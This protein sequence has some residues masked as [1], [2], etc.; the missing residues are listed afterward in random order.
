M[1][2]ELENI[3]TQDHGIDDLMRQSINGH[4]IEPSPSVWKGISRK[5][6]WN[7]ILH[8]NFTNV[9]PRL[10]ISAAIGV[11][12]ITAALYL[13]IHSSP[14][15]T[16]QPAGVKTVTSIPVSTPG[17]QAEDKPLPATGPESAN[18]GERAV[19]AA[20]LNPTGSGSANPGVPATVAGSMTTLNTHSGSESNRNEQFGT[21]VDVTAT[22]TPAGLPVPDASAGLPVPIETVDHA[23]GQK[24]LMLLTPKEADL[25]AFN[26]APDT[27]IPVQTIHGTVLVRK[28]D[29]SH[30]LFYAASLGIQPEAAFNAG[31]KTS[32]DFSYW[33]NGGITAHLSRFSLTTG[34]GIGSIYD[35]SAYRIEYV[36]NDSVGYYTNVVSYSVGN[37]N[38]IT[39]QTVIE[40]IYD[41]VQH[42]AEDRARNRTTYLQVP[43]LL[44]YRLFQSNNLSLTFRV[45]PAVSFMIAHKDADPVINFPDSRI[46]RI[47]NE[48]PVRKETTWQL[49]SDLNLEIRMNHGFSMYV[50]PAFRYYLT[51][52]TET[53]NRSNVSPPWSVGL[54]VGIQYNFGRK[55]E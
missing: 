18:T 35:E 10:W 41:S 42:V 38:E 27:L 46:I 33:I 23:T 36:S 55:K 21:P 8:F 3:N 15:T 16:D 6:L 14:A 19:I 45:G 47:Q 48:T 4:R 12:V 30:R 49:W 51:P 17:L 24:F 52:V 2:K 43:F 22:T 53:E 1:N 34:L 44:G 31:I 26:L 7:E 39:Y 9:T 28:T 54:G 29:P 40:N 20:K 37:N 13:V 25:F 5:L 32:A 50:S 11:A